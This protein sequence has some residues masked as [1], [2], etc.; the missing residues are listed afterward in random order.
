MRHTTLSP[1]L[2]IAALATACC[3]DVCA[4]ELERVRLADDGRGFVLATSGR[5]FAVWGVNYD[6]DRDGRLIEDYW[7]DE[8]ATIEQDFAEIK[9]LGANVVRVHLQLGR[10]MAAADRPNEAALRQLTRLL[11]LAEKTELYLDLTGLGCYHKQDVPAWYD[12]LSEQERWAV[13][14]RFWEAV[15][16]TCA[17]SP[18]LFCYDLMNEPVVPGGPPRDDWLGPAFAGKHFVQFITLEL[19]DRCARTL[20]G[21]GWPR[22]PRRFASTTADTWS[23]WGWWTGASTGRGYR[24]DLCPE[25]SPTSWTSSPCTSIRRPTSWTMP[26]KRCVG[27]S[28]WANRWWSKRSFR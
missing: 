7:Q 27:S 3:L 1:A 22:W 10:F 4:G 16:A 25:R 13:Q 28:R 20:P 6:H 17:N 26:P 12:G 19:G 14:A 11:A 8:W 23:P 2:G 21:V 15:A 18:A 5:P 24:P 9:A